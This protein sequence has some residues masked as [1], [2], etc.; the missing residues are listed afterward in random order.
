[1]AT[2]PDTI[3]EIPSHYAAFNDS[4]LG[5]TQ[6]VPMLVDYMNGTHKYASVTIDDVRR[7]MDEEIAFYPE[8][9]ARLKIDLEMLESAYQND[10]ISEELA[11]DVDERL[12]EYAEATHRDFMSI[13]DVA[14]HLD[15]TL[16]T[17]YANELYRG[18]YG[19]DAPL[20]AEA[21]EVEITPEVE[22]E[23][24]VQGRPDVVPGLE[25][26]DDS[27]ADRSMLDQLLDN[28]YGSD[29]EPED[30]YDEDDSEDDAEFDGDVDIDPELEDEL[31]ED[32][33]DIPFDDGLDDFE[34]GM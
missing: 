17:E 8:M 9:F 21:G 12:G 26:S 28:G 2:I 33:S 30:D 18:L 3:R 34:V 27:M 6:R 22:A 24:E 29:D 1:M 11:D 13:L 32:F 19:Q 25:I 5:H 4:E 15:K 23:A 10:E 20:S 7:W 16:D 14:R 31:G